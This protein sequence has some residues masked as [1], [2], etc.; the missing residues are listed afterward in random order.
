MKIRTFTAP[1]GVRVDEFIVQAEANFATVS[2]S[3]VFLI[4][5]LPS[6]TEISVTTYNVKG[7]IAPPPKKYGVGEATKGKCVVTGSYFVCASGNTVTVLNVEDGSKSVKR[8][9]D[10]GDILDI[11]SSGAGPISAIALQGSG[12][13]KLFLLLENSKSGPEFLPL[14]V[15]PSTSKLTLSQYSVEDRPLL[16]VSRLENGHTVK[17]EAYNRNGQVAE[18]SA[19]TAKSEIPLSPLRVVQG[20]VL[21]NRYGLVGVTKDELVFGTKAGKF[22]HYLNSI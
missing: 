7:G 2:G 1:T 15:S 3:K 19:V 12:F 11:G 22:C 17:M 13:T 4:N 10:V 9:E 18:G 16:F 21:N 14:N 8:L 6:Q 20:Y 5:A